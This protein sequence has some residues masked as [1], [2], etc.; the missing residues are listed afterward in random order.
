MNEST[1]KSFVFFFWYCINKQE[2]VGFRYSFLVHTLELVI[3][4]SIHE[5][6]VDLF[7]LIFIT[8][9]KYSELSRMTLGTPVQ[10]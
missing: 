2:S 5:S 4:H 1:T 8:S 7:Q 10:D 3:L 9:L 6:V